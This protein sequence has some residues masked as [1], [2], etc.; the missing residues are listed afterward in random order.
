MKTT[1][2]GSSALLGCLLSA[3]GVH[4]QSLPPGVA[5]C[6]GEADVLKR[7]SC[8]DREVA[9]YLPHVH[10]AA[11]GTAGTV[12]ASSAPAATR[13]APRITSIENYPDG[14]VL[15]L[16][17]GQVWQED[18]DTPVDLGLRI[19]DSVTLERVVG[20]WWVTG[21]NGASAKVRLKH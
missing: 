7:L 10:P 18:E 19:G 5:A 15:H 14:V 21:R 6:A 16:D 4:A 12:A 2:R 17:N 20:A 8:Y 1:S 3:F 11:A 13:A 9:P